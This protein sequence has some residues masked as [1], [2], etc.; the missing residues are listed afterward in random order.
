M[1]ITFMA[2]RRFKLRIDL[3]L[4]FKSKVVTNKY[5]Q[6]VIPHTPYYQRVESTGKD[7]IF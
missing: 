5:T 4:A 1:Y 2:G 3:L 7:I 6:K